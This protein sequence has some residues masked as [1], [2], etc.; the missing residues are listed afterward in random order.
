MIQVN[1]E[2]VILSRTDLDFENQGVLNPAVIKEGKVVNMFYRAVN[3]GNYSTIGFC[4]LNGPL[5]VVSRYNAPVLKPMGDSERRGIE[6]P[7]IVKIDN[8]YHLTY[9]AYDGFNALGALATT[10]DLKT[11]NRHGIIVPVISFPDFKELA[12]RTYKLNE[13]YSRFAHDK[14]L[15]AMKTK[16]MLWDKD[17]IFFPRRIA[18]QLYFLHRIKPDIQIASVNELSDLNDVYWRE[19]FLNFKTNI[20]L[21]PKYEHEIS[22][23]GGGCPPIETAAGWLIIYHGVHDTSDGYVY[24]ACAALL[25]PENPKQEIARL[26]YPL[27]EPDQPWELSG[28]VNS[29]CFPS[30]TALFGDTLY[31]YYGAADERIA[32]ASVSLTALIA[33]LLTFKLK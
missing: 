30:G 3:K 5:K 33:E 25:D 13:K 23:L 18:N 14:T 4:Q 7:R 6:D 21:S 28:E 12:E 1:K 27:F 31:I 11:Y 32:C 8:C 24:S 20:L 29:V 26:P 10:L 22:Y 19:Y 15:V 16:L 9:T 17:V 2:G